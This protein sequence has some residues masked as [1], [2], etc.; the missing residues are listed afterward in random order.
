MDYRE[1]EKRRGLFQ[2]KGVGIQK[3]GVAINCDGE[4]SFKI[5]GKEGEMKIL[6][7]ISNTLSL[8][9]LFRN[10]NGIVKQVVMECMWSLWETPGF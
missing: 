7:L 5:G 8:S 4:D 1:K 3:D 2:A 6:I 9:C 10:P